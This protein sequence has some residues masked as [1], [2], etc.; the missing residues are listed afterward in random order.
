MATLN[1][2]I[3]QSISSSDHFALRFFKRELRIIYFLLYTKGKK[4]PY[5]YYGL[6]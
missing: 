4:I 6:I 5:S 3:F 1:Q 2:K